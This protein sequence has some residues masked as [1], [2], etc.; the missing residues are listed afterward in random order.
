[1]L[2]L[3]LVRHGETEWN[4]QGRYQ[5]HSDLPLNPKG[6]EQAQRLSARLKSQNL[7]FVFS[8]DLQRA[9]QTAQILVRDRSLQVQTTPQLRE[10]NFGMLEGHTFN[11]ALQLWPAMIDT[12]LQDHNQP[13]QGG[14][15]IDDFK[16]RVSLFYNDL[17]QNYEQKTVLIVAHGGP[18]REI[19]QLLL[20]ANTT[21]APTWWIDLDHASLSEFQVDPKTTII[22]RLN[23][24][25]HLV[26]SDG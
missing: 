10:L 5:G 18:L 4:V 23:D 6:L 20:S 1:M 15:R 9:N 3:L 19:I 2:R 11:E 17:R 25:G 13:P 24:A 26:N 12:W 22:N 7:D 14:E 16:Q 8:S 21:L